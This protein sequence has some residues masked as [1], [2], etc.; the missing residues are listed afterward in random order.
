MVHVTRR[1]VVAATPLLAAAGAAHAKASALAR[2]TFTHGVASGDPTA[3]AV[4]LWTRFTPTS[5]GAATVRWEIADDEKFQHVRAHG[6]ATASP[7]D[8]Y[9]IKV[10]ARGLAAGRRY[11]YRFVSAGDPSPTGLTRTAP[12]GGVESLSFALFSCANKPFGY[13]HAYAHAA[14][15][16]DLDLCIHVGDYIYEYARGMYP[17]A[18]ETVPG[19]LIEPANELVALSDYHARYASYRADPVLQELHR[20]KPFL[21]VWDDH[22]LANDTWKDGAENHQPAT[23]GAW[24]VRRVMAAKAYNDWMPIR[25][26]SSLLQIYRRFDWGSLATIVMLDTRLIGRDQQLDWRTALGP[27]ADKGPAALAEAATAFERGPLG[28]VRRSLL[29]ADQE[30]WM[31]RELRRSK[32][33]GVPWQILAQQIVVGKQGFP[34]NA[35]SLLGDGASERARQFA[36]IGA[37]VGHLGYGWNLDSWSGYPPARDRFLQSCAR[38][39]A[40]A[41]VLSGDSHNAWANNLPGGRDGRPAAIEIGGM[42]VSSPGFERTF[43]NVAPGGREQAMVAANPELAWCD[44]THRGYA[45][46]KLTAT[47]VDVDWVAFGSITTPVAPTPTITHSSAEATRDHGV[48]PWHFG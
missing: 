19:R 35:T 37:L 18:G 1:T 29:G 22:E 39:G 36:G 16:E 15:R 30:A 8:D 10:D 3:S 20:T 11:F 45:A 44:V 14:A 2:G 6:E 17:S 21:A 7:L 31:R 34:V 25:R 47:Q 28:D 24:S 27:V 43:T 38:D 13:F 41:L 26:Q 48:G 33:R 40:N 23:E 42:S 32:S 46:A 12:S 5:P 4:I 9:C